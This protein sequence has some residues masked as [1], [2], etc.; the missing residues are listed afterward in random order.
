MRFMQQGRPMQH[1]LLPRPLQRFG[2]L[3]I[4]CARPGLCQAPGMDF[5]GA[6]FS[7]K[8]GQ[9]VKRGTAQH[10]KWRA[11]GLQVAAGGE[12]LRDRLGRLDGARLQGDDHRVDIALRRRRPG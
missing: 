11:G 10:Q 7:R 9:Q 4:A 12:R 1:Q 6:D 5:I 2:Q 3:G 8:L